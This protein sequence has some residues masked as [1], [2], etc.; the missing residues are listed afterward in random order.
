[1]RYAHNANPSL[2]E[3]NFLCKGLTTVSLGRVEGG[4]SDLTT[5]RAASAQK[6]VLCIVG[7]FC[8]KLKKP[9]KDIDKA[10]KSVEKR[11]ESDER[12]WKKHGAK[13][14]KY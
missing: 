9:L 6:V 12:H 5:W 7:Y 3:S 1:M 11:L 2:L 10:L 14:E 13:I 8:I 4:R